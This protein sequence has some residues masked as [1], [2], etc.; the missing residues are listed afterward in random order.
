M[1]I[2]FYDGLVLK[3]FLQILNLQL[4]KSEKITDNNFC[5]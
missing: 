4:I 2:T 5:I 1:V 3:E